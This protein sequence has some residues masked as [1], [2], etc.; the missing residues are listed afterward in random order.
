[1]PALPPVGPESPPI[2]YRERVTESDRD[3]VRQ[4]VES[5]GFFAPYEVEVAVE[6]VDERLGKGIASGYHFL[7][8]EHHGTVVGYS[9]FGPIACT[10][11]SFDLYW[12][13]VDDAMRGRGIGRQLM[14]ASERAIAAQGGRRIY[15]ETSG[16]E[17]YAPTRAFYRRCGYRDEATLKDFYAVGD[18][19]LILVKVLSRAA[20]AQ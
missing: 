11:G 9:C 2:V 17:Q 12:I 20:T 4:I 10:E 14:S 7:F 5:T 16:R 8:A 3:C 6:L 18:D 13:A 1:M 15:V 19:K